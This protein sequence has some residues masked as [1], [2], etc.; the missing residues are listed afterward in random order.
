[1]GWYNG[2]PSH[3]RL[4]VNLDCRRAAVIGIGNV[5]MDVVRVLL[6]PAAEL[7]ETDIADYALEAIRKSPLRE[8]YLLGRRGA[9]QA[10][11][12]PKE[13]E[14]VGKLEGVD[15]V[16]DP[17]QA[18]EQ[19]LEGLEPGS[20]EWKNVEYLRAK[21]AEGDGGNERKVRLILLASPVEI[22]GRDGRVSGVR[23]EMNRLAPDGRGGFKAQGTGETADL[24]AG[25][26]IRAVGYRGLPVPGVPFHDAWGLIP[27]EEGRVLGEDGR[28]RS[29]EYVVGWA[30]RGPTGLIGT[31]QGDSA[32]T[33]AKM[34]EDLPATDPAPHGGDGEAILRLLADRGVEW[35]SFDDWKLLDRIETERGAARGRVREKILGVDGAMAALREAKGAEQQA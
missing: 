6:R 31:N 16:V 2:H 28:P 19:D 29:G 20:S 25:L 17:A 11:F 22:L 26:V 9:A 1:V 8:I 30:K 5:A 18:G 4:E 3:E 24:E 13:I 23:Y 35:V 10:A 12:T 15:L 27:N 21:A 34:M 14:E 7:A 32:A 33:V